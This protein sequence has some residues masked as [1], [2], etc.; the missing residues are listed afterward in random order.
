MAQ[1]RSPCGA[2]NGILV[3]SRPE[4]LF[5][6]A[7]GPIRW[8]VTAQASLRKY[9]PRLLLAGLWLSLLPISASA[10]VRV[11]SL[12]LCSDQWLV[13]LAPERVAA[14]SL[15]ARDPAL[16]FVATRAATMPVVRGSAEAVLRLHPDLVLAGP[17]G[18]QTTVALLQAEGLPIHRIDLPQDFAGI[19]AQ[20]LAVA[21]LLGVPERGAALVEAMDSTLA[22]ASRRPPYATALA[23]EPRGYTAGPGSL[24]DS[25][26]RAAGLTNLSDGRPLGLEGL[27]RVRPDL[28]VVPRAPDYPSLATDMLD[29]PAV[30]DIPR[31]TVSPALTVCAGPFT[32]TAVA[33]LAR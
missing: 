6:W 13:L 10:A 33:M 23:W 20:A 9:A 29:N 31:R 1:P 12:N 8:T 3:G 7:F 16:S 4:H 25:V 18:A 2:R 15:L 11:V 17:Y 30:A 26:L 28:L 24:M 27:L 14:L 32:A 19:R 22:A 5:R 21:T